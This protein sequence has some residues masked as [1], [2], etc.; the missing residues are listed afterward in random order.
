MYTKVKVV[1]PARLTSTRLPEKMLLQAG[2]VPLFIHT[3]NR[4]R[5]AVSINDIIIATDSEK[6]AKQ[7]SQFGYNSVMTSPNCKTGTDRVA[8]VCSNFSL[9]TCI[10]N[11]QG[12]EVEVDPANIKHLIQLKKLNPH[13]VVT[14]K[15]KLDKETF[16]DIRSAKIVTDAL[17]NILYISR[18]PIP[19]SKNPDLVYPSF[20]QVSIYA[21]NADELKFFTNCNPGPLETI[22]GIELLRF[23]EASFSVKAFE[24]ENKGISIDTID[25]YEA[26]KNKI[27]K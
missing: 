25:Q 15:Y 23:L 8:E 22:E 9:D 7:A 1:I 3:A 20:A 18:S 6:I 11:V 5:E 16:H 24:M 12:D 14:G 17:N 27:E 10:I 4:C 21:F 19:G 2:G 26:F 13:T